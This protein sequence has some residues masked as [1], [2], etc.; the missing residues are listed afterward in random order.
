M[1]FCKKICLVQIF[2]VHNRAKHVFK[3]SQLVHD[4]EVAC[5]K[6]DLK[7]MG[8]CMNASHESC[9]DLYECSCPELD[10]LVQKCRDAGCLGARL[11]GAGNFQ[12][13]T[14]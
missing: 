6:G 5:Q 7:Q 4:F 13:Q 9:K 2:K 1:L 12:S 14:I 8:Q 3:E 10:A 11:T